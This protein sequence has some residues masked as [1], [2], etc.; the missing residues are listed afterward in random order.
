M[1]TFNTID[2]QKFI[3]NEP[4]VYTLL[5][6]PQTLSNPEVHIQVR[7]ERYPNRRVDFSQWNCY[8]QL[9]WNVDKFSSEIVIGLLG[10]EIAQA[11]LVQPTNATVITGITLQA[12]GTDRVDVLSRKDTRRFRYRTDVIVGNILRYFDTMRLQR[13]EGKQMLETVD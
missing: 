3:F 1:G 2:N 10:R 8:T 11:D 12:T 4:G 9:Y 6:I 13:F 5:Y 7:L